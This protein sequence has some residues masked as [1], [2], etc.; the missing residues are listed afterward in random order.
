MDSDTTGGEYKFSLIFGKGGALTREFT[1][2]YLTMLLFPH[3]RVGDSVIFKVV[4]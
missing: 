3:E 4:L 2:V 1:K